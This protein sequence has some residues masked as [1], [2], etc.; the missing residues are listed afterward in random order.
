MMFKTDNY[1]VY[2]T[3][4]VCRIDDIRTENFGGHS[5][6]YY[7][8]KPIYANDSTIYAPIGTSE[9][10]MKPVMSPK[11]VY[12]L[13]MTMPDAKTFW[14]ENDALR[15]EKFT[16]IVKSGNREDLVKLIKTLYYK[17]KEKL[18]S[19]KKFHAADEKI[20]KEAEKILYE[21]FALVLNI[22][23]HEVIPFI[24]NE[25]EISIEE[26]RN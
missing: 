20:M 14:I 1:I 10:R 5:R 22:K 19:G 8:L 23:L 24:T 18:E 9:A 25:L 7:V 3:T 11:E 13:I 2:G 15:K 6:E 21:E 4:G 12:K 16:E 17:R 26:R